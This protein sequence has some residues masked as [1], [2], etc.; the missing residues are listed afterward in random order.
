MKMKF[1]ILTLVLTAGI[2][3]YA[4]VAPTATMGA[5]NL[6]YVFRYSENAYFYSP[7]GDRQTVTPSA[8]VTYA[9]AEERHPF[10][11]KYAG[12]YTWNIAGPSYAT[13][14]FQRLTLS[15]ALAWHRWGISVN[16]NVAYMPESPITGFSGIAGTGEPIGEPNP[17]PPSGQSILTLNTHVVSNMANGELW[18]SFA[19]SMTLSGGA[20]SDLLRYPDGNGL[21]TDTLTANADLSRDFGPRNRITADYRFSQ[22]TYP[23]YSVTFG[24]NAVTAA[25]HRQWSR[26]LST[27]MMIGPERLESADSADFPS[28]TRVSASASIDYRLH[29]G[30][31]GLV[32]NHGTNGGA[33]YLLGAE[34]DMARANFSREFGRSL[35]IGFDGSYSRTTGLKNNG[36]TNAKYAGVQATW[37]L[38]EHASAFGSYTAVDQTSSS[39]LYTS[40]LTGL[41]HLVSFGISYSPRGTRIIRH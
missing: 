3:A 23:G 2:P 22:Y 28:S 4:Q 27:N 38:G 32:Y 24:T 34:F 17:N 39:L 7:G 20:G 5:G 36:V 13:G 14:L 21:S 15:Q 31:T 11:L 12:G 30:D 35:T 25:F 16:D 29:F 33:G 9:N 8:S 10:S 41:E 1:T 6:Q 26:Q 18:H 40:A 19:H 37:Q